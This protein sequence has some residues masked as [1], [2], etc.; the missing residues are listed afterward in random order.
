MCAMWCPLV[1]SRVIYQFCEDCD[2]RLCKSQKTVKTEATSN[3]SRNEKE[4]SNEKTGECSK[5]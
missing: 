5:N 3:S 1:K 4:E 2:E